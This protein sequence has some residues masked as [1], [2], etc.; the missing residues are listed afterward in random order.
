MVW[1]SIDFR[2]AI[3]AVGFVVVVVVGVA[4]DESVHGRTAFVET[5]ILFL[6][7]VINGSKR[8]I[9]MLQ[10]ELRLDGFCGAFL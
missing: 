8:D 3:C 7:L 9:K 1:F 6:E 2:N 5:L 10:L 4:A